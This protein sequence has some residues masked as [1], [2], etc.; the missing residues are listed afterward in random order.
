[1]DEREPTAV[2]QILVRWSVRSLTTIGAGAHRFS[3]HQQSRRHESLGG[4]IALTRP[5][6]A[7]LDTNRLVA[8]LQRLVRRDRLLPAE[9]VIVQWLVLTLAGRS[10]GCWHRGKIGLLQKLLHKGQ[11]SRF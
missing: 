6:V 2:L 10:L 9:H 11:S 4:V 5:P 7:K 8:A 3:L 1:M